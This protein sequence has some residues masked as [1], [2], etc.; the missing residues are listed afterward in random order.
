MRLQTTLRM[1][2]SED[3]DQLHRFPEIDETIDDTTI[4]T[5]DGGIVNLAPSTINQQITFPKVTAAKYFAIVVY[6]GEIL[7]RMNGLTA[8]AISIMPNPATLVDPLPPFQKRAQYGL[9][10]LGPMG[11]SGA[12][13]SL[14][15][16]NP[17]S[18]LT[19]RGFVLFVGEA[20]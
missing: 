19:A 10:W 4:T 3:L 1:V 16:S 7:C 14:Y 20:L 17:S 8:P 2:L 6:S 9:V 15:L 13:T 12:L 5:W 18:A 11:S